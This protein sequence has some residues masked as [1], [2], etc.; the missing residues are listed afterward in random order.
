[1]PRGTECDSLRRHRSI[2][3]FGIVRGHEPRYID[4]HRLVRWFSRVRSQVHLI[5]FHQV[6]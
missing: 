3:Y 1:M 5:S 2:R 4:Q 6:S